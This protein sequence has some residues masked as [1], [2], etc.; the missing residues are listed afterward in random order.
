MKHPGVGVVMGEV[1][2][3]VREG[4]MAVWVPQTSGGFGKVVK[5]VKL[6]GLEKEFG[7]LGGRVNWSHGIGGGCS[8]VGGFWVETVYNTHSMKQK[9]RIQDTPFH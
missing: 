5:Q 7:W 4:G 6:G 8:G 9:R 2:G 1:Q 3:Q